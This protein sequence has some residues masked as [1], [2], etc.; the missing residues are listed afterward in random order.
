[1]VQNHK[2]FIFK[3]AYVYFCM[4]SKCNLLDL[5]VKNASECLPVQCNQLLVLSLKSTEYFHIK[6]SLES[7][8]H[9]CGNTL[10]YIQCGPKK[11]MH[12]LLINI[13]GINR[14]PDLTH[15]DF[16][17]WRSL[18]TMFIGGNQ[19]HWMIYEKTSQCCV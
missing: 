12:S 14:S 5:P 4:L 7:M 16:Y 18:R 11:C 1:M 15:L 10:L 9:W 6:L 8:Y 3:Q 17:L 13:F 19:L 2:H